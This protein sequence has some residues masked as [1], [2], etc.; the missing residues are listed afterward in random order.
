MSKSKKSLPVVTSDND[1]SSSDDEYKIIPRDDQERH[2]KVI[3]RI[4]D[5]FGFTLNNSALSSGKSYISMAVFKELKLKHIIYVGTLTMIEE[6]KELFEEFNVPTNHLYTFQ[7]LRTIKNK[8]PKHG[9]LTRHDDAKTGDITFKVTS[10]LRKLIREGVLLIADEIQYVRNDD[11]LQCIAL[12]E[13]EK[14]IIE[15]KGPSK[16]MELSGLLG[17]K[18]EYYLNMCNRFRIIKNSKLFITHKD[19]GN[20]ELLGAQELVDFCMNLNPALTKQIIENKPFK[21]KNVPEVCFD[22][23]TEIV[24][25]HISDS[26]PPPESSVNIDCKNGYY[27]LSAKDLEYLDRAI[28][29]FKEASG[30]DSSTGNINPKNTC[31]SMVTK[32]LRHIEISKINIFISNAI[33]DLKANPNA[34]V[35][36][37]LN[38]NISVDL[39]SKA[40]SKYGVLVLCG[41]VQGKKR[42]TIMKKFNEPNTIYRVLVA[43]IKVVNC[44]IKLDDRNGNYPRFIYGSS[45]FFFIEC[46]QFSRRFVRGRESLSNAKLRFVYGQITSLERAI[47]KALASHTEVCIRTSKKQVE[48]GIKF[49]G[50]YEDEINYS[51]E[52]CQSYYDIGKIIKELYKNKGDD[53]DKN[54]IMNFSCKKKVLKEKEPFPEIIFSS[55]DEKEEIIE[56]RPPP[57]VRRSPTITRRRLLL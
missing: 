15:Y 45:S 24:Q 32:S 57:S 44:G 7:G 16:V 30:F 48:N 34:K 50:E 54:L 43:N 12:A 26:M 11:S 13:I 6:I 55:D 9:F 33:K 46:H 25:D 5:K 52:E 22:L 8:Q 40:L 38:Y 39:I 3:L 47:L 35:C 27:N 10:K 41:K 2:L 18:G 29:N 42:K 56:R 53:E 31:W 36:I 28:G 37:G 23:Y 20:T 17:G 21:G 4:L 19:T 1:D 14:A 51:E 49:P